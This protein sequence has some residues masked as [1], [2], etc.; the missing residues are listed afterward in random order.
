MNYYEVTNQCNIKMNSFTIECDPGIDIEY[1]DDCRPNQDSCLSFAKPLILLYPTKPTQVDVRL[2]YDGEFRATFPEY[3]SLKKGW[4]V[5]ASPES[6][7][8]DK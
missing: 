2:D 1:Y 5:E 3:P 8:Q 6:I 4:S 7:I